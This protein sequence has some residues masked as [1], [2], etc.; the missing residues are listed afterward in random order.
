MKS[1][2]TYLDDLDNFVFGDKN[3]KK[4]GFTPPAPPNP[5]GYIGGISEKG[6]IESETRA[7]TQEIKS[8]IMQSDPIAG[9]IAFGPGGQGG[10]LND[11][12]PIVSGGTALRSLG[13][14]GRAAETVK[15]T[16]SPVQ[17]AVGNVV[18][19]LSSRLGPVGGELAKFGLK[20]G[21]SEVASNI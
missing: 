14:L 5:H 16:L 7:R 2:L 21:A 9:S 17:T 8:N 15:N 19:P 10:G 3:T 18:R 6:R 4:P 1:F 20:R 11:T 12:L 13:S